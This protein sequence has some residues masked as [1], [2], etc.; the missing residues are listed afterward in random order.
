[1][2][3][4]DLLFILFIYFRWDTAGQERFKSIA[5]SYYRSANGMKRK[6]FVTN[7]H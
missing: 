1:M 2:K 7:V 4:E 6:N 5:A 3:N